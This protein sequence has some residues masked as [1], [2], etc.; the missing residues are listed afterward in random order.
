[1]ATV[2]KQRWATKDESGVNYLVIH[3]DKIIK[4]SMVELTSLCIDTRK[5]LLEEETDAEVR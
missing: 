3:D 5:L 4:L 2:I 1:M